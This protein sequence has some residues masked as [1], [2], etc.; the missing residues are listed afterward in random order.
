MWLVDGRITAAQTEQQQGEAALFRV[1]DLAQGTFSVDFG[2]HEP[3]GKPLATDTQKLLNQAIWRSEESER[4]LG[5][6]PSV[7][8][9]LIPSPELQPSSL[10]GMQRTLL[11]AFAG[12]RSILQVHA[13][14]ELGRL[15]TLITVREL[16]AR[17]HLL[18]TEIDSHEHE[19]AGSLPLVDLT[20]NPDPGGPI[21]VPSHAGSSPALPADS[22]A[23]LV[24]GRTRAA[25]SYDTSTQLAMVAHQRIVP[26][27]L[28]YSCVGHRPPAASRIRRRELDPSGEYRRRHR[29]RGRRANCR[30]RTS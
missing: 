21:G 30:S 29:Q 16:L 23:E 19:S 26:R 14:G 2:E 10:M 12:G 8:E 25:A 5:E 13:S 7:D 24:G 11:R 1:F 9:K 18:R 3:S 28:G 15:E 27:A 6:L 4:L 22:L 17:G 20:H